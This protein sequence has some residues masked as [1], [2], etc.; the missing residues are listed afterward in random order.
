MGNYHYDS[1]VISDILTKL[2]S[3]QVLKEYR[4]RLRHKDGSIRHVVIDSSVRFDDEGNFIN[5][6]CFTRDVTHVRDAESLRE[7]V[8]E[9]KSS[10]LSRISH[11][12]R[13]P[14]NGIIGMSTLLQTTTLSKEQV[15]Y[16][17]V[18]LDSSE[19]LMHIVED[20]LDFSKL[21]TGKIIFIDVPINIVKVRSKLFP[22][23]R[24]SLV[25]GW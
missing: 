3:K 25:N 19:F 4:A 5:T 17:K 23:F 15:D 21:E 9:M 18:V 14:L 24:R 1:D 16:V 20:I 11:D 13:T 7:K 10:F 22:Y 8:L 6:R 12:I 2:S